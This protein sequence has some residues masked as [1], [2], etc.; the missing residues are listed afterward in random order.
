MRT[1]IIILLT[2][3]TIILATTAWMLCFEVFIPA[4]GG[5]IPFGMITLAVPL[6]AVLAGGYVALE[7]LEFEEWLR[8]HPE[9][10]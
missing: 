7:D 2:F 10:S 4:F 5:W 6:T 3:Y 9:S 8:T 1:I